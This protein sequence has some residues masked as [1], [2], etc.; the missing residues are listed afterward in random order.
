M[1]RE[2]LYLIIGILVCLLILGGILIYLRSPEDNWIYDS[3][4]VWVKHGAPAKTPDYVLEQQKMIV[5]AVNLYNQSSLGN[6]SSQCLGSCNNYAVDIVHV[7]RAEED[8][9]IGNQCES[10][11]RGQ[12]NHFI[13]LD[14]K[15]NIVRVV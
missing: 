14:D 5:C 1:E 13:E 2:K 6:F 10:I 15:G 8:D 9:L 3:R 11:T 4:G 7:P 12:L